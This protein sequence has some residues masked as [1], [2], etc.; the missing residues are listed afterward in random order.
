MSVFK[1]HTPPCPKCSKKCTYI[2]VPTVPQFSFKDGPSG[3]WPSKGERFKNYRRKSSEAADKRSRE[4]YGPTQGSVPNFK[5]V[6]TE[7]WAEAKEMAT[8]ELGPSSASTY[9]NKIKSEKKA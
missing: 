3:S 1:E 9:D 5:G 6:Q 4:R 2:Y 7:S 8:K